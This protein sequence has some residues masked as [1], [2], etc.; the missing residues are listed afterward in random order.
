MILKTYQKLLLGFFLF[1]MCIWVGGSLVRS[2]VA[3]DLFMPTS[4]FAL[5]PGLLNEERI[6]S[7]YVFTITAAYT[8]VSYLVS[9]L[10]FLIFSFTSAS[11]FR[12]HGW[13]F[14]MAVLFFGFAPI[15]F[16]NIYYDWQLAQ[17][18]YFNNIR[19]FSDPGVYEFFIA[20]FKS[21]L[22]NSATT[23]GLFSSITVVVLFVFR[24]VDKAVTS[25]AKTTDEAKAINKDTLSK[26]SK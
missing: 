18:V 20:R 21:I 2:V 1:G 14:M 26:Y 22:L 11:N 23:L 17:V 13:L 7:V 5:R 9:F 19:E 4:D 15:N 12:K 16:I 8:D 24:P 10:M 6:Q 25:I 3:F